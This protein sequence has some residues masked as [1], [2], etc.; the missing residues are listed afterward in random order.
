LKLLQ[1]GG[2]S[3]LHE[4]CEVYNLNQVDIKQKYTTKALHYYRRRNEAKAL[5][6]EFNEPE[7]SVEEGRMF[8]DGSS[9]DGK[10]K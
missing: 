10:P 4:Y 5:E 1:S 9:L 7:L 8:P 2:N 3:T 6:R